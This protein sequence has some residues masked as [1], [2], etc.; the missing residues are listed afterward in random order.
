MRGR[1]RFPQCTPARPGSRADVAI[2]MATTLLSPTNCCV[3]PHYCSYIRLRARS[4]TAHSMEV[5]GEPACCLVA[6][7]RVVRVCVL[8]RR[9][10]H[11]A[12]EAAEMLVEQPWVLHPPGQPVDQ[13]ASLRP[14]RTWVTCGGSVTS[15]SSV[16][17]NADIEQMPYGRFAAWSRKHMPQV[18]PVGR[19]LLSRL[20]PDSDD[21]PAPGQ[22]TAGADARDPL[23]RARS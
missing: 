15:H 17:R 20:A 14:V 18:V 7:W 6:R 5:I 13:I 12:V 9:R 23:I 21:D 11:H 1:S 16:T 4:V 3:I 10:G 8:R 2:P 19:P 22:A